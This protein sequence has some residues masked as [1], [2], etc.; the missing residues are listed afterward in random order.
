MISRTLHLTVI[1]I[2]AVGMAVRHGAAAP[3]ARLVEP[4]PAA[5]RQATDFTQ[6]TSHSR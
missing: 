2:L 3:A 5:A 4:A 1:D 6:L